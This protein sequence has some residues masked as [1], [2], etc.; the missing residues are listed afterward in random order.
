MEYFSHYF[1]CIVQ[2]VDIDKK[3]WTN[4]VHLYETYVA[5]QLLRDGY[6]MVPIDGGHLCYSQDERY[7]LRDE[8]CTCK[9]ATFNPSQRCKHLIFRDWLA[10]YRSTVNEIRRDLQCTK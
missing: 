1:Y 6:V 10:N 9:A 4:I 7:E 3:R 5:T 2:R 8:T